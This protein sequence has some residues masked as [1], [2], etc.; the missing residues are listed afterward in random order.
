MELGAFIPIGNN[1]W[2]ISTTSPQYKPSFDLK[3]EIVA[4]AERFGLDFALSMIQLYGFAGPSGFWDYNLEPFTPMAGLAAVTERIQLFASC[5]V[6]TL[7]P[8]RRWRNGSTTS[9]TD[10]EA[11]GWHDAQ[12]EDDPSK[13]PYSQ[14]NRRRTH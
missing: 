1:G 10:H 5:A 3:R 11:L 2:P 14:P 9:R 7:P 12:A 13:D 4:K 8:W 6:P